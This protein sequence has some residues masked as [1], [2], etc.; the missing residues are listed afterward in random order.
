[1]AVLVQ[2]HH[3]LVRDVQGH[4]PSEVIAGGVI[5]NADGNA[6]REKGATVLYL[7][8]LLVRAYVTAGDDYWNVTI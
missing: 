6:S 2:S 5:G 8:R 7:R 1:M 3:R 4:Q